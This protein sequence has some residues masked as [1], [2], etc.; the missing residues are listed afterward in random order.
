M[1]SL[2]FVL[3]P[4]ASG[5]TNCVGEW[6]EKTSACVVNGDSIQTY[7]DLNIGSAKPE[8][9]RYSKVNWYLFDE[10][11][12]RRSGQLVI[13]EGKLLRF[14]IRTYLKKKYLLWGGADFIF[15]L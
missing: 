3:G 2:I 7:K 4:T 5:K 11:S 6:A 10:V 12:A 13:L 8:F 1:L 14:Y 9:K 15:R